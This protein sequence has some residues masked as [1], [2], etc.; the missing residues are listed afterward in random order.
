VYTLKLCHVNTDGLQLMTI[1]KPTCITD[2]FVCVQNNRKNIQGQVIQSHFT[3]PSALLFCPL[4]ERGCSA[5]TSVM[6]AV[7]P[8]KFKHISLPLRVPRRPSSPS[9]DVFTETYPAVFERHCALAIS[10]GWKKLG[11]FSAEVRS[12]HFSTAHRSGLLFGGSWVLNLK[13]NVILCIPR[14]AQSVR[15]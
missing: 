13:R 12:F 6:Q 9:R 15:V 1:I 2:N 5:S 4:Q 8:G 3:E 14:R 11:W 7:M 10:N